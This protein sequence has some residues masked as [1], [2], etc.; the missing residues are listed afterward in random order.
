MTA[1]WYDAAGRVTDQVNFGRQD[2]ISAVA[3]DFFDT[4]GELIDTNENGIPDVNESTPPA[5][6]SSD[7]LIV[8]RYDYDPNVSPLGRVVDV[9][10]NAGRIAET[11]YDLLGRTIRTIS[12]FDDGSV[13]ETDTDQDIMTEYQYDVFGRLATITAINA[14]GS[15][16]GTVDEETC[17]LYE[18]PC[19]PTLVTAQVSPDS[20]DALSQDEDTLEWTITTDNGDHVATTYDWL[21]RATSSTDQRG[22]VHEYSFDSAGRLLADT[23]TSLGLVGQNVDGAIRRIGYAYDDLGRQQSITSYADTSGTEVVNQVAFAYDGWGNLVDEWQA[24]DGSVN[25]LTTPSTQHVFADGASSGVAKYIRQTDIIYPNGRDV[26]LGYGTTGSIDDVLSRVN[27]VGDGLNTYDSYTYLGL[28]TIASEDYEEPELKLDFAA[29][30]FAAWDQFGRT[31]DQAWSSYGSSPG[32]VDEYTY[33]FDRAGNRT[34]RAN[35]LDSDLSQTYEY[36]ALNQLISSERGSGFTQTWN[37]DSLGNWS[38]FDDNGSSQT[39]ESNAANEITSISG[40]AASPEYDLAG[41]MIST[42]KPGDEATA[43]DLVF[44]AWD[45][46][47]SADDGTTAVAYQY[48]GLGRKIERIVASIAEHS[49]YDGQQVV[50]TKVPDGMSGLETNHQYVWSLRYVDSP[51]LRDSYTDNE[52]MTGDRLYYLTDSNCNVTA[53]TDV[54]GDVQE[55][56]D[57]DTYGKVTIYDGSWSTPTGVSSVE[58]M[59]FFSGEAHDS[60]TGLQYSRNRWYSPSTGGFISRDPLGFASNDVNFYRYVDNN[61][62]NATDPTG[63]DTYWQ[64]R[65]LG[66]T[67]RRWNYNKYSHS[68]I[69][70]TNPDGTISHTYSWGNSANTHGWNED[71]PEDINAANQ[72]IRDNATEWRGDSDLDPYIDQA[73]HEKDNPANEHGWRPWNTCKTEAR[74]LLR[75]A[76]E[77][78]DEANSQAK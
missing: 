17:Y 72:A 9:T 6:N 73:F 39:R 31:L 50:E 42:P 35:T 25:T 46:L 54:D 68:F 29:D 32:A 62:V 33:T 77:L 60:V 26:V 78:Q 69:F 27:T 64:N 76:H 40:G 43:L 67:D 57:Y 49:Y 1:S 16:N 71:Q 41:N 37:L 38:T 24:N 56:Y 63:L 61:P 15:G 48:D 65:A 59:L 45:R 3:T 70:T 13:A 36:D 47:V 20:T 30:N 11:Q 44:D 22:V 2:V 12:N 19:N 74:S 75:R 58:N 66:G 52:I 28:G 21:G 51:I 8:T 14:K 53:V 7:E 23:V 5:P 55:R 4:Y 18:S 34:S 10:D